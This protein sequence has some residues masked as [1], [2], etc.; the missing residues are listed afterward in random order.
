MRIKFKMLDY[1]YEHEEMVLDK[2]RERAKLKPAKQ[3]HNQ[4]QAKVWQTKVPRR[5]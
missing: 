3:R 4:K 1:E 5:R 2:K